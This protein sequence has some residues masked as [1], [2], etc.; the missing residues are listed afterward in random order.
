MKKI[1]ISLL[2]LSFFIFSCGNNS[3]ENAEVHSETAAHEEYDHDKAKQSI[4]LNNGQKWKV[5]TEMIPYVLD[6]EKAFREYDNIDYKGLAKKLEEKNQG[7]IKSC[8]MDGKSH[9]ELH[10]WLHPHLELVKSLSEAG[11]I[12][13][14]NEIIEQLKESFKTYHT[15]FQ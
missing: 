1:T 8:T 11:E 9:D 4:E 12:K 14:A 7:L 13:N 5:N 10:K 15:Y 6:A 3:H 2:S